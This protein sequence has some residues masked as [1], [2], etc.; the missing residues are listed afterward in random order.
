[1]QHVKR[2]GE[3]QQ[4]DDTRK[5]RDAAK[6]APAIAQGRCDVRMNGGAGWQHQLFPLI[7]A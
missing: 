7:F 2:A 6:C 1:L 3:H 5:E 4:V